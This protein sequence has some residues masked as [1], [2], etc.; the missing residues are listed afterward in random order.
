MALPARFFGTASPAN[1]MVSAISTAAPSPC[2]ARAA[3]RT[4]RPGAAP[5]RTDAAVNSASPASI[6]RRRPIRSPSRPAPTTAVV[7]ASR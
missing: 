6:R 5:H 3:T 7:I 4:Q 1:A 2:T